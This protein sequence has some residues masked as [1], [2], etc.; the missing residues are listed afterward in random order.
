MWHWLGD[1]A[2]S[3]G[4]ALQGARTICIAVGIA[5]L[6]TSVCWLFVSA[7]LCSSTLS[8]LN[9]FKGSAGVQKHCQMILCRKTH[10]ISYHNILGWIFSC[11]RLQIC[12]HTVY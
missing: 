3:V 1:N 10:D 4:L 5:H 8:L 7:H 2:S 6:D 12:S 11:P 9:T